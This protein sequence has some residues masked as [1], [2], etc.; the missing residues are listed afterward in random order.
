MTAARGTCR[1]T[2]G[3]G[4]RPARRPG[5]SWRALTGAPTRMVA[6]AVD[7]SA[8]VQVA[9]LPIAEQYLDGGETVLLAVKPS[10]WFVL[11]DSA[12]WILAALIILAVARLSSVH[13]AGLADTL[14]F[15]CA[16]AMVTARVGIAFL[17][18]A[19]R[20]YVLT[21]RRIMLLRGVLH[22]DIVGSPLV[23]IRNTRVQRSLHERVCR[24]GTIQ[25]FFEDAPPEDLSWR[26]IA[27]CEKV[28]ETVRRA[29]ERALDSQPRI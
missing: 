11:F 22:A 3:P 8:P 24:L 13:L 10:L 18:W 9:G 23:R 28:H 7:G 4:A 6:A 19:S 20:F 2:T 15:Q 25:F 1:I 14:V 17:R 5:K 12:R 21:N 26:E 29:I 27:R 16:A